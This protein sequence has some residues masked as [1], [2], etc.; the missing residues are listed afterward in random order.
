MWEPT[1][2][3]EQIRTHAAVVGF[4]FGGSLA[5]LS[6]ARL[7]PVAAVGY[8]G[9]HIVAFAPDKPSVPVMLHFGRQ[10]SHIPA[11]DVVKLE[12][13]HP[14]VAVHWYDAG[15]AFNSD[16]RATYNNVAAHQAFGR[17]LEFLEQ[18]LP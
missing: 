13:G 6:A 14:E 7:N 8:Y 1:L 12:E 2:D 5:L 9:G 16:A 17:A 11:S 4:C 15:H 10:D 3:Y 18:H